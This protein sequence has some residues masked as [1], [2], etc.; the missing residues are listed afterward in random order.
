MAPEQLRGEELNRQ[1]DLYGAA[2]V[3]WE[4]LTCK[5]LF[6]A[7]SAGNVVT[8]VLFGRIAPPSEIVPGLPP[9]LDAVVLRGL[10]RDRARRFTTA[11]EMALA[12]HAAVP[13]A[14]SN[15]VSEWVEAR[16]FE[17]LERR[18]RARA[19][20]ERVVAEGDLGSARQE[21]SGPLP[22]L[23][24]VPPSLTESTG[25]LGTIGTIVEPP[26]VPQPR[27][28]RTAALGL[29]ALLAVAATSAWAG[30]RL[31]R[32][33]ASAEPPPPAAPA[34]PPPSA[35]SLLPPTGVAPAEASPSA[36][37]TAEPHATLPTARGAPRIRPTT[38][39]VAG[40]AAS[41]GARCARRNAEGV[42][43]FDTACLR[44]GR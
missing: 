42:I 24:P 8:Q 10:S 32:T 2:V 6:K 40:A 39:R 29:V 11:K 41:D 5:R 36:P 37:P 7:D 3:L 34:P 30:A 27:P 35:E 14:S 9:A 33:A 12:L 1:A 16:A 26:P 38:R 21:I 15:E 23:A 17:F 4:T 22:E 28:G 25:T 31:V 13:P 20:L 44:E 18:A 19:E 43:E